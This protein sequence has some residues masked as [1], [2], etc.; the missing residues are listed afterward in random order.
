MGSVPSGVARNGRSQ[1]GSHPGPHGYPANTHRTGKGGGG[2]VDPPAVG[3]ACCEFIAAVSR[4]LRSQCYS[5]TVRALW[6][7]LLVSDVTE[8]KT[9]SS[10]LSSVQGESLFLQLVAFI[11]NKG[12]SMAAADAPHTLALVPETREGDALCE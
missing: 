4:P 12:Q 3:T 10:S 7:F 1:G 11:S 2:S 6:S 9:R 5:K 8:T